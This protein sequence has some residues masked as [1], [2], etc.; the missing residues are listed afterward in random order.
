[1]SRHPPDG[2]LGQTPIALKDPRATQLLHACG[3]H[4][5]LVFDNVFKHI[6]AGFPFENGFCI[7]FANLKEC[8]MHIDIFDKIAYGSQLMDAVSLVLLVNFEALYSVHIK[9][10]TFKNF[11]PKNPE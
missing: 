1:M 6:S 4:I 7:A 2:E 3:E 11:W 9:G 10:D 8:I 5:D